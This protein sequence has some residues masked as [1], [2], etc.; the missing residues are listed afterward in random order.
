MK[1]TSCYFNDL[2]ALFSWK[3]C[4][5]NVLIFQTAGQMCWTQSQRLRVDYQHQLHWFQGQSTFPLHPIDHGRFHRTHA[6]LVEYGTY[7]TS[8]A[9]VIE[10]HQRKWKRRGGK[11]LEIRNKNKL[12]G[13]WKHILRVNMGKLWRINCIPIPATE[14]WRQVRQPF[15]A[16][17]IEWWALTAGLF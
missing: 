13:I 15:E 12:L 2:I 17:I 16:G 5:S 3:V 8:E 9:F 4:L 7:G 1:V 11:F 10:W 14:T 6:K